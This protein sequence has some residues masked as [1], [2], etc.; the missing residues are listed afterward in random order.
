MNK[1]VAL[2]FL[3][4]FLLLGCSKKQ[5]VVSEEDPI[6]KYNGNELKIA[7]VGDKKFPK[8]NKVTFIKKRLSDVV[9][10]NEES[11]DALII[12]KDA[13]K[14]ADKNEYV[15]FYNSVRYPVFFY[16]TENLRAFAFTN[17]NITIEMEKRNNTPYVQG[18]INKDNKKT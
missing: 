17:K 7:V 12:T 18:Y 9:N 8:I 3:I 14:E 16:G 2:I 4:V 11:F 6:K 10:N 5:T 1:K 13:F 15:S